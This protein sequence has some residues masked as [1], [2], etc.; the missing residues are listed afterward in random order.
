VDGLERRG[1]R[2]FYLRSVA[3][4]EAIA[5]ARLLRKL[6]DVEADVDR[7]PIAFGQRQ[8]L[9]RSVDHVIN[10]LARTIPMRQGD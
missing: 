1:E 8:A 6:A 5:V 3:D 2:T 9:R 7:L 10:G 4:S